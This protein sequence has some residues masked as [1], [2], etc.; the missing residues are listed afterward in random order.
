MEKF[1]CGQCPRSFKRQEHLRRHQKVHE[2]HKPFECNICHKGFTR[3]DILHKH[4][5]IHDHPAA[6]AADRR[7]TARR[8]ACL[9]CAKAREKCTRTTPCQRCLIKSLSC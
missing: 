8:R 5:A 1:Q 7:D 2:T 4:I 9:E 3:S 6:P